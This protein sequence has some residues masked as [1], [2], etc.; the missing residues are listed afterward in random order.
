MASLTGNPISALLLL[1]RLRS[2]SNAVHTIRINERQ[3]F[4]RA[5]DSQVLQEVFIDK[6]YEFLRQFL[7]AS[8]GLRILDV[9]AHIG[10]FSKWCLDVAP[11]ARILSV[12][13]DPDTFQVLRR[14]AEEFRGAVGQWLVEQSAASAR[15]GELLRF[16]ASG[17]SMS[18]RISATGAVAV[19]SI[20]LA[21][22][23]ELMELDGECVDVV[24]V[25][26]E[27]SEEAFL[28]E[29]S[30]ALKRI[31]ALVV[32]LHPDL[33][34]SQRVEN[35]IRKEFDN[36]VWIGGRKSSKPLLYCRRRDASH[37]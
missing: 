5:S 35:T 32:E 10:T 26:I 17:P 20:S 2:D 18:H 25:D 15:D 28:C 31:R 36:I 9:G 11:D 14:N 19:D 12:E 13:A 6:E 24:K 8:K 4:F 21:T 23:I 3:L 27:G 22:L 29:G 37:E 16:S 34:D 33:C 1:L 7:I 30:A